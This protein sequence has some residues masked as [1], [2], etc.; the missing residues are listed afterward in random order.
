M[1]VTVEVRS[2]WKSDLSEE[3]IQGQSHSDVQIIRY[4]K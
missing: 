1:A 2:D 3:K 4:V